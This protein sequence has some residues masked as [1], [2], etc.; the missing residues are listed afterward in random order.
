MCP[1]GTEV[2]IIDGFSSTSTFSELRRF[3]HNQCRMMPLDVIYQYNTMV[4]G[5]IQI[6][7]VSQWDQLQRLGIIA[8]FHFLDAMYRHFEHRT[9]RMSTLVTTN[10]RERI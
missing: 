2:Q 8:F 4:K 6:Q 1:T 7:D 5:K 9:H 10:K 3:C